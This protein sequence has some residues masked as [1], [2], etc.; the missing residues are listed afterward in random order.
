MTKKT[1]SFFAISAFLLGWT[2]STHAGEVAFVAHVLENHPDFS[3]NNSPYAPAGLI[4]TTDPN[5]DG[6]GKTYS[7]D[8]SSGNMFLAYQPGGDEIFIEGTAELKSKLGGSGGP[9][10]DHNETWR[11]EAKLSGLEITNDGLPGTFDPAVKW[12]T[13]GLANGDLVSLWGTN[14]GDL[15]GP[16]GVGDGFV[17][18]LFNRGTSDTNGDVVSKDA[19]VDRLVANF[20][21]LKLTLEMDADGGEN[22]LLGSETSIDWDEAP[23]NGSIFPFV[24]NAGWHLFPKDQN[25]TNGGQGWLELAPNAGNEFKPQDWKF[26]IGPRKNPPSGCCGDFDDVIPEPN[27]VVSL[28]IFC[29]SGLLIR[30]RKAA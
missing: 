22:T 30:R 29:G 27:S 5:N 7:L 25:T 9:I 18:D 28:L 10:V 19:S 26:I 6:R 14:N 12:N 1:L 4:L 23:N 3:A 13:E 21:E 11:I 20:V 15:T 17:E 24:I 16:A 2:I 8:F